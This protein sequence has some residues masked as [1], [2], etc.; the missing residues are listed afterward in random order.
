M[1]D[2]FSLDIGNESKPSLQ[3]I[4]LC[5]R[6]L[7]PSVIHRKVIGGFRSTWGAQAYAA[8]AT[9][10]DTAKLFGRNVF[11]TIVA[12]LGKPVLPFF[13]GQNP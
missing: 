9:V 3:T 12:L 11:E 7:R 6:A 2:V 1:R 10:V 8:L 13:A 5:E 4:A